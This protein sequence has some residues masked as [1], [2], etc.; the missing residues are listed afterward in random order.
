LTS[1]FERL[2]LKFVD[3]LNLA[4]SSPE[5][6]S[7]DTENMFHCCENTENM[8]HCSENTEDEN[9][10]FISSIFPNISFKSIKQIYTI[11][12]LVI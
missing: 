5:D 11:S 8:L 3:W 7:G 1:Q 12:S 9:A 10:H 4:E 6:N 2:Y